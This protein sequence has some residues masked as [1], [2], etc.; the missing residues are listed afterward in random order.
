[1]RFPQILSVPNILNNACFYASTACCAA[2]VMVATVQA[3]ETID[4]SQ[5]SPWRA[6]F[7]QVSPQA[8]QAN[9]AN[10]D[11]APMNAN[12]SVGGSRPRNAAPL[13]SPSQPAARTNGA[14]AGTVSTPRQ[15]DTVP[16][17]NGPPTNAET[18]TA[19][20]INRPTAAPAQ[21]PS[22]HSPSSLGTK[23]SR[24]QNQLPNDAGQVW[25]EY[26]I[27]PYT[28]NVKSVARP[29]QAV[30]NWVLRET[31]TEMWF[32]E[33]LGI[34]HATEDRLI[35]Y[36]TPEIQNA[37]KAIIDRFVRTRGQEQNFN[38]DLLTVGNPNW[39]SN[40]YAL[41]QTIDVQTPGVEA[42]MM[43]KENAAILVG[44]LRQRTDFKQ[45]SGGE[46]KSH[47][48]QAFVLEK[49]KPVPFVRSLR[50][51]PGQFPSYEPLLTTIN[52]GYTLNICALSLLDNRAIEVA[53]KC[54]VDQVE[55]LTPIKI[56][57]GGVG[58]ALQTA[59]INVPELIS[60]RLHERFRW[61]SD[62]VLLLSCGVVA[63]PQPETQN[64]TGVFGLG[65]LRKQ[66]NRSDALLMIEYRGPANEAN[67]PRTAGRSSLAPLK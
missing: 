7:N 63:D 42:W 14:A 62:Q 67:L 55:T 24:T 40:A 61:P 32:N 15:A 25:R 45:H 22:T 44:Q 34:L 6:S 51:L 18:F 57:V 36:H 29:Q 10:G 19:P 66:T 50:W 43:S 47:D 31:G 11:R 4:R 1:M 13:P 48:G 60:W 16:R 64:G 59:D 30:L 27:G 46:V 26:D 39:R 2:F 33:P 35:V 20:I 54:D 8:I 56:P 65:R 5:R 53:I 23:V 12:P 49:T 58:G 28:S 52:E 37:V 9:E 3:Q 41:L 21:A 38:V 17:L